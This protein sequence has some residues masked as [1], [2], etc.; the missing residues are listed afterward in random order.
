MR[1]GPIVIR[2]TIRKAA[3]KVPAI[4]R[5]VRRVHA[6]EEQLVA[7]VAGCN[8]LLVERDEAIQ[9]RVTADAERDVAFTQRN[10][11]VVERD[12]AIQDRV[13]ADAERDVAITQRNRL[14]VERDEAIQDRV[15]ADAE[16]DVAIT[17]RNRLVVERDEAIQDRVTADAERDVAITQRNRLVVER[18]EAIQDRA[19]ATAE[20]SR[21]GAGKNQIA[22]AIYSS[23][24]FERDYLVYNYWATHPRYI[25][26][27]SLP[28]D[29][30]LLDIGAGSGG[31]AVWREWGNPHRHDIRLFGFDLPPD[32]NNH[33]WKSTHVDLYEKWQ[34]GNLETTPLD[35]DDAF[36]DGAMASNVLEHLRRPFD[37]LKALFEKLKPGA[38]VYIEV[39]TVASKSL[40]TSHD[41]AARG[42]QVMVANFYDDN[43]HIETYPLTAIAEAARSTGYVVDGGGVVRH[44]FLEELMWQY[45]LDHNDSE[46]LLHGYWSIT[47]WVQ[48]II[49][50][51]PYDPETQG[52]NVRELVGDRSLGND[53]WL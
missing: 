44:P 35:F 37:V 33:E 26:F 27:K 12:E 18:G 17:Q 13:A 1:L 5:L 10:E 7:A 25:F 34:Y 38:R 4:A 3:L 40:P 39:P 21:T 24:R 6:L 9:L 36:F 14:L 41:L 8:M 23:S 19:S 30:A 11:L 31:T 2:S 48:Y 52:A 22:A 53:V 47:G 45:G 51:R 43:T 32:A 29:A 46:L 20:P 42:M 50:R 15:T 16:R 28:R 49:L